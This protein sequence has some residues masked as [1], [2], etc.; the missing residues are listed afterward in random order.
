GKGYSHIWQ[1]GQPKTRVDWEEGSMFSPPEMW[2]HQHFNT[3]ATPARYLALRWNNP[4]FQ[5]WGEWWRKNE[6][7][8][9]EQ[10]EYEDEEPEIRATFERELAKSGVAIKLPPV[11]YRQK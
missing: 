4:E 2:Y 11:Q 9:G 5:V 10:I 6:K 3:G 8:A 1:E 7:S